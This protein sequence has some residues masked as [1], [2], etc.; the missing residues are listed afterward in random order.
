MNY[1]EKL[2]EELLEGWLRLS[3]SIW[4]KRLVTAMTYNESLV[5]NLLC[6]QQQ[7][8]GGLLTPTDLCSGLQIRKSQM[9]VILNSLEKKAW[10]TRSRSDE[11][12]R[13]VYVGLTEEGLRIYQEAHRKILELPGELISHLG[14]E[15]IQTFAATMQEVAACFDEMMERNSGGKL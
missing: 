4:N 15:K 2:S 13:N 14:E 8:G 7:T 10:I 1:D 5:C 12:K 3:M 11:D 9:N 6:K